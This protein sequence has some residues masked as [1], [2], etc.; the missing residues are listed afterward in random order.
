MLKLED[1]RKAVQLLTKLANGFV[2]E[3]TEFTLMILVVKFLSG[4]QLR[5]KQ[6]PK[7]N[8]KALQQLIADTKFLDSEEIE[9]ICRN[10]QEERRVKDYGKKLQEKK[11]MFPSPSLRLLAKRSFMLAILSNQLA[12]NIENKRL[13][14]RLLR[15][16]YFLYA[17]ERTMRDQY[18]EGKKVTDDPTEWS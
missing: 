11:T 15:L 12:S 5:M 8:K 4:L 2:L 18:V 17:A 10:E 3:E 6:I 16:S 7:G 14:E 13:Q 9:L 1:K